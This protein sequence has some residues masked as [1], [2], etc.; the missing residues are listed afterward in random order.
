MPAAVRMDYSHFVLINM[1]SRMIRATHCT[2]QLVEAAGVL[3]L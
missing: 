2:W 3:D 1:P